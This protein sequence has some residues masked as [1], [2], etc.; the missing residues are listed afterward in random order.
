M[1]KAEHQAKLAQFAE[2]LLV[3]S[4]ALKDNDESWALVSTGNEEE[5]PDDFT[6][7]DAV[8]LLALEQF[9][10]MESMSGIHMDLMPVTISQHQ[11]TFFLAYCQILIVISIISSGW[12]NELYNNLLI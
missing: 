11:E 2:C 4:V 7:G 10:L 8:E 9:D 12:S 6:A 5:E 1:T 3:F